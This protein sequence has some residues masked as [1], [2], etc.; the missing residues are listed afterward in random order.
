M[1]IGIVDIIVILLVTIG[2]LK[3][4]II[5]ATL[6]GGAEADFSARLPFARS[7]SPP[8][9]RCCSSSQANFS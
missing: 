4:L 9:W 5:Y 3:A 7:W 8:S 6:A 1:P 2:P